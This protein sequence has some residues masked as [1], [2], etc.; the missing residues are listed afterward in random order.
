[1]K[2]R[3]PIISI[4]GIGMIFTSFLISQS[5]FPGSNPTTRGETLFPSLL[6]GMF[7]YTSDE[8][9]IF[10]S[11]SESFSYTNTKSN[12]PLLWGVHILDYQNSDRI[13]IMVSNI[14]GDNFGIFE[15][16]EP[17]IFEMFIMPK[18]DVYNFEVVNNGNR[19]ITLL[20]M[21]SEDPNNSPAMTDPNSA[22]MTTVL[23]LAIS[24]IIMMIG[25]FILVLGIIIV[26]LDW[27]RGSNQP[28][29]I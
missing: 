25:I 20:I 18:N 10:P 22:L 28:R 14:F 29:Y 2:Q 17:I 23:P 26:I 9:Q 7:D 8:T 11:E 16:D 15:Q 12:V 24:G 21:F 4:I 5:L 27:K 6:E 13:S 1:M 3:G 19:P